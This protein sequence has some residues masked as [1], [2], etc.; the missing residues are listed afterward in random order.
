[1]ART[2]LSAATPVSQAGVVNP[3]F[4][5]ANVDGNMIINDGKVWLE[6]RNDDVSSKT[7]T[8]V[9]GAVEQGDLAIGDRTMVVPASQV[10]YIGPFPQTPYNQ[11]S[12]ADVGKIHIDYS[13]VTSVTIKAFR[14]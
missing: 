12:G 13:A 10:G 1:M 9:T 11:V 3:T 6:V 4:D 14:S 7:V 8:I 5:A 2:D